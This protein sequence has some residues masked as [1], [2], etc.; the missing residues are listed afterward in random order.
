LQGLR[1]SFLALF[2]GRA[3]SIIDELRRSRCACLYPFFLQALRKSFLALFTRRALSMY[4]EQQDRVIRE[5]IDKWM[6]A[7]VNIVRY[8]AAVALSPKQ[9]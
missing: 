7:Q 3:L 5:F 8:H 9:F 1:K 4:V 2:T 6:V